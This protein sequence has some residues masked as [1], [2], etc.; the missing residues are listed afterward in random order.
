[1]MSRNFLRLITFSFLMCNAVSI[2]SPEQVESKPDLKMK[3]AIIPTKNEY[4]QGSVIQID[5]ILR[6]EGIKTFSVRGYLDEGS[7][8]LFEAVDE[9]GELVYF[10]TPMP[11]E[12]TIESLKKVIIIETGYFWGKRFRFE[13]MVTLGGEKPIFTPGKYRF[14]ATY[15]N[16]KKLRENMIVGTF[17]SNEIIIQV[18]PL[19]E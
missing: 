4:M 3:I 1:M 9:D 15:H 17:T 2:G 6:N 5:F 11:H 19:G 10:S 8:V 7:F 16:G 13:K 18:L 14:L 12:E